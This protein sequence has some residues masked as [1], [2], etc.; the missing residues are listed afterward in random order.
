MK[1]GGRIK[2]KTRLRQVGT[3]AKRGADALRAGREATL[4]RAGGRCESCGEKRRLDVHHLKSRARHPGA[5]WLHSPANL[6]AFCRTCHDAEH[7]GQR[8]TSPVPGKRA[9]GREE[10]S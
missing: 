10:L 9:G 1:R 3:R 6:R 8:V 4:S 2:R 5:P 7:F